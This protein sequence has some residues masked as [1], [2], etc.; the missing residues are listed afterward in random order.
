MVIIPQ[1]TEHRKEQ[2]TSLGGGASRHHV[3][4]MVNASHWIIRTRMTYIAI[5][6]QLRTIIISPI[7]PKRCSRFAKLNRNTEHDLVHSV[8]RFSHL[9]VFVALVHKK[10]AGV[11]SRV[12]DGSPDGLVHGPHAD[13]AVVLAACAP[14]AVGCAEARKKKSETV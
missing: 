13:A 9:V 1:R 3:L 8:L 14:A 11:V 2:V 7:N 12:S 4:R 6:D 10:D 5:A